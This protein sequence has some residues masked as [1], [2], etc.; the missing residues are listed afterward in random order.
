MMH[1]FAITENHVIWLDLPIVFDCTC[2][3]GDAV[4]V[5]TTRTALGSA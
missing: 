5:E 3:S 4:R 1:D 2:W